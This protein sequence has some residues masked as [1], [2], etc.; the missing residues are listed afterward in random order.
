MAWARKLDGEQ[1]RVYVLMG[2]GEVAEGLG[3]GS[4]GVRRLQQA[5][6]RLRDHR[7]QPSRPERP[8]DAPAP[9]R[10]VRAAVAGVRLGDGGRGRTRRGRAQDVF[11]RA[12]K[13]TKPFGIVARTLKGK[14]VSFVEDKEGW[15][16]KPLK[17]GDELTKA[18]A[19]LGDTSI[20]LKVE[21]RHYEAEPKRPEGPLTITPAYEKGQE[22]ATREAFGA[23]LAKL[24]KSAPQTVAVDGDT[25]NSTFSDKFKAVAPER[26][27]EGYI[28][29]QNMVGWPSACPPKARSRSPRPLPASSPAPTTSSAWPCTRARSTSCSAAATRA[30]PSARTGRRRWRSKTWP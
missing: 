9:R 14:G 15:H 13:S 17:K 1:G 21:T 20:T 23:A 2:D 22:V 28:A 16:G 7:P 27:A 4:L 3:L 29:E 6:Q 8:H 12:R 11:A 26:F 10:G 18:V 19:E 24:A 5:L 30:S 25:K